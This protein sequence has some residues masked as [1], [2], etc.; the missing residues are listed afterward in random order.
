MFNHLAVTQQLQLEI[1]DVTDGEIL[2]ELKFFVYFLFE[3]EEKSLL[4]FPSYKTL[5]Q[6]RL[7]KMIETRL[8][9]L[10]YDEDKE[11]DIS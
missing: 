2:E 11:G 4:L 1:F 8:D 7:I 10:D 5:T 9:F 3:L 6:A